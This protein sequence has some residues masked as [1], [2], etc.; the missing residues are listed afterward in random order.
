MNANSNK[1][2]QIIKE[3]RTVLGENAIIKTGHS[4]S[5]LEKGF[6]GNQGQAIAAV[7]PDS[8][9][10]LYQLIACYKKINV[11]YVLQGA[12]TALKGQG[13]PHGNNNR[14]VVIIQTHGLKKHII[15][16]HP[17]STEYKI[18]LVQPGLSLKEA[19]VVLDQAGYDLPHKIGSHEL[20]NTFGG[21]CATGCGGV[22]VDNRAGTASLTKN[23]NAGVIAISADG[24]IYNGIVKPEKIESGEELLRKIDQNQFE[25]GD[26]IPPSTDEINHFIRKMF[27]EKSF[28]V[29]NHRGEI[30]FSGEGGEGSQAFVYQMY[31]VRKK[32]EKIKTYAF[33]FPD[34]LTK[35]KF[36]QEIIF[37]SGPENP[38]N[39]PILCESMNEKLVKLIAKKGVNYAAAVF[40]ALAPASFG[41]YVPSLLNFRNR[42][43][44]W[45]KKY[46]IFCE[47]IFGKLLSYILTPNILRK[48]NYFEMV[49]VQ[50]AQRNKNNAIDHF[51][52]L[53]DNYLSK[54][55]NVKCIK[56]E[57]K[58][59][60]EK[61]LIQ[62]RNVSALATLTL[63][64][65]RNSELLAFDDAVMPGKMTNE[66]CDKLKK[67]IPEK[68]NVKV[69]GP[70]LYGHD[71][72]Q[73]NHND[74]VL[75]RKLTENESHE[76]HALQ[77]KIITE[78]GGIAHAEHGVGDYAPTDLSREELVKL[79]AHRLLNDEKGIAN[80][81]GG[82]EKAY[83]NAILDPTIIS[84]ATLLANKMIDREMVQKTLLTINKISSNEIEHFLK[85][86]AKGDFS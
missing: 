80:P 16:S 6:R 47:N 34:E 83:Q 7:S 2:E 1:L 54:N 74:W 81:G 86:K 35:E 85:T 60:S 15:L 57:I 41:K 21:S 39:F 48:S 59:F 50:V 70:Y 82:Q 8:V 14:P 79:V 73:I 30:I 4:I 43:I 64:I 72:K 22:R 42:C 51:E 56:P 78:E 20:G 9:L 36:Y 5:P 55:T 28:P 13:T 19:E 58:S 77:H 37:S 67:I 27:I 53:V 75:S 71:L 46:Y 18:L 12:N 33:L 26:I 40:F 62:I 31:L 23:G 52:D 69:D 76:L 11:G 65:Y 44:Q 61:L 45:F 29:R 68:F 3:T 38:D 17:D 32:P 66:Y 63:S 84:D 25:E 24:I 49:L 10:S